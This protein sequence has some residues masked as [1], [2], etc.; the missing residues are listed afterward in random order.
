MNT[1]DPASFEA[2]EYGYLHGMGLSDQAAAAF[3]GNFEVES[4]FRPTAANANEG[5]IGIAQWEGGRRSNGL[6]VFAAQHGLAE[7]DIAAQLGYLKQELTGPYAAAL[8]DAQRAPDVSSAAA[9]V[10]AEFEGSAGTTRSARISNAQT[11]LGQIQSGALSGTQAPG[12]GAGANSISFNPGGVLGGIGGALTGGLLPE[13]AGASASDLLPWNWGGDIK[14]VVN[15]IIS[16]VLKMGFVVG[17]IT[18]VVLG[19]MRA[20]GG[21]RD[22]PPIAAAAAV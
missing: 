22:L 15:V 17:G 8:T 1:G 21:S 12:I 4:G 5:A 2:V 10:D 13:L 6:D 3:L 7:T 11:I 9:A 19:A 20:S 16:F 14:S 18:L